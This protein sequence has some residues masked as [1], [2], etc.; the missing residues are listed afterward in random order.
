M[1]FRSKGHGAVVR[2]GINGHPPEAAKA[3][4]IEWG[5]GCHAGPLRGW[6]L[7]PVLPGKRARAAL[8]HQ[9]EPG[10]AIATG[11]AKVR[12]RRRA[13][14]GQNLNGQEGAI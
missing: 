2:R 3:G 4:D 1:L 11:E 5:S 12:G 7:P 14:A 10:S 8:L 9:P 6:L 13:E